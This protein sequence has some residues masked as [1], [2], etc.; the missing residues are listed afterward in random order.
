[1]SDGL[2]DLAWLQR[3]PSDIVARIRDLAKNP[4]NFGSRVRG[5][6]AY[7]LDNNNLG[8][9]AKG[10]AHAVA[11]GWSMAPLARF[12]LGLIS[13]STTAML[14]PAL[15]ASAARHGLDLRC[16]EADYGQAMQQALDPASQI[17]AAQLDAVLVAL[18]YRGLPLVA[19]PGNE[20]AA[21][22]TVR[23]VL[24]QIEAIRCGLRANGK[25]YCILQTLARPPETLFGN[26]DF[27]LPGTM[28][29]LVAQINSRLAKAVAGTS[30]RLFDVGGLA[31]SV[32]LVNWH[33][34]AQWNLAKLPFADQCVP[35]Y[36][37]KVG[38]LLAASK[39]LS[40]RC[41]VLDLDNTV[42][43]GVI[44][45][46]GMD[47]IKIGQG[48]PAGE[49]FLSV[50]QTALQL[51]ERG[52]V[53]AVSS[54]NTD[55]VARRVFREHPEMLLREEHIAVFQ[56]NWSD[57]ATNIKAIA[58]TL[59][60]GLDSFVFLDDNPVERHLVRTELPQVAVPELPEDPAMYARVL[61]NA[62]YF[63]TVAFS[64]EDRQRAAFYQGNAQR[65]SLLGEATD[66]EAYLLSLK[67]VMQVQPF[68]DT[69]RA[70]ITQLINKSNQFNL[71]TRRY[72]EA[73]VAA[74][75]ADHRVF[76]MQVRLADAMGDNGMISVIIC[77]PS[78]TEGPDT[79]EIDSWL[80][81]CR[82]LGRKVERGV[83][84]EIF[85]QAR[86][87]GITRLIGRYIPTGRNDLV[88][89]HYPKLG[90]TLLQAL[91]DGSTVWEIAVPTDGVEALPFTVDR[92]RY[93]G[94]AQTA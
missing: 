22:E 19:T 62:G 33:D 35:L 1:M 12:S 28:R 4:E 52:I 75:M 36:A 73:D 80:M 59:S 78:E 86:P 72:S 82:V 8:R 38:A 32:G 44:G 63:E 7:A 26:F 74:A 48:D 51:R 9:V 49:A 17:N 42:W 25:T 39:G 14:V 29:W 15:V 18:D 11:Q 88:R 27:T 71:T 45:D 87:R 65:A 61:L 10:M 20:E 77:R 83:L 50:Q 37:D 6:T 23:R 70:R 66:M 47:G 81:S 16:T 56:A 21:E 85:H 40:R 3:Q 2:I 58:E 31:E 76:T 94:D 53:L 91:D 5:V 89:E 84:Q 64:E 90:F 57:K 79:W 60:L 68:D 93:A 92:S 69:G 30:D 41:L 43:G 24:A 46:D 13:N 34:P 54:K 55:D 67:M